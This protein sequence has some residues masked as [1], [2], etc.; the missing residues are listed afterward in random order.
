MLE[1]TS[2]TS[3]ITKQIPKSDSVSFKFT[4]TGIKLCSNMPH[5]SIVMDT[6]LCLNSSHLVI[7]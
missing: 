4:C 5:Y 1:I 2:G 3:V 6:L 7:C